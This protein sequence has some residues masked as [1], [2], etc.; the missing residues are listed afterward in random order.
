MAGGERMRID[1]DWLSPAGVGTVPVAVAARCGVAEN[2]CSSVTP[3]E[4][5]KRGVEAAP[6]TIVQGDLFS[7]P[8]A[9]LRELGKVLQRVGLPPAVATPLRR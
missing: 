9:V 5:W 4:L 2:G 3:T 8:G 6:L 7:R 1:Y